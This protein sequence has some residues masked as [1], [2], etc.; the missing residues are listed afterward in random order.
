MSTTNGS[1]TKPRS[2]EDYEDIFVA[3]CETKKN[4]VMHLKTK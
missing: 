3:L 1:R 2:D 4:T